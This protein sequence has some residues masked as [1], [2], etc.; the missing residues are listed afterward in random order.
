[1]R[2]NPST[3]AIDAMCQKNPDIPTNSI[4]DRGLRL[5]TPALS[6]VELWWQASVI[7]NQWSVIET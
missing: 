3:T 4:A 5:R 1:L 7:S 2:K 6:S